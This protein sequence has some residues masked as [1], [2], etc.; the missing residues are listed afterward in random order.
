MEDL[1]PRQIE[2][3]KAMIAEYTE[4]GEP[5]G[6]DI[7]DKKYN[8]GVSPATIRNEM[9]VLSKNGYLRKEYFSAGRVPTAKA[10]RFY[11]NNLMREKEL[12]TAEEVSHKSAVWDFR[13]EMH[14]LLQHAAQ[15]LA[16]RTNMLALAATDRGDVYYFGVNQILSQKEFWDI[17]RARNI[18]EPLE[19]FDL[20]DTIIKRLQ[21]GEENIL[22]MF[23]EEEKYMAD[24]IAYVFGE[25]KSPHMSGT[26]GVIGPR[27]M[28]YDVVVPN[29]RYF[30]HLI[31]SIIEKA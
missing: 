29:V 31:E 24:N 21:Q 28:R 1:T 8:L 20:C 4:T 15:S 30:S 19:G 17:E 6:S 18:F 5:I 25:F 12:S 2:L 9:V 10:F 22:Y 16:R 23:A 27:R 13:H 26:I 11:I 7:L 3:L 14:Q